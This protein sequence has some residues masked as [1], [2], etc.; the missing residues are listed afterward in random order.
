MDVTGG[1]P[2]NRSAPA[3]PCYGTLPTPN[4]SEG[5]RGQWELVKM[6]TSKTVGVRSLKAVVTTQP[7]RARQTPTGLASQLRRT[8][9]NCSPGPSS[10]EKR[11][12]TTAH[13]RGAQ[14]LTPRPC[15]TDT[16]PPRR[17]SM[18][19]RKIPVQPRRGARN[20]HFCKSG[21]GRS[22]DAHREHSIRSGTTIPDISSPPAK[23]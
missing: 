4:G 22:P 5:R 20:P 14:Y 1:R 8:L 16:P 11:K 21:E 2:C 13:P 7:M 10:S 18:G 17:D 12:S 3:R 9:C 19:E 15:T 6:S 23:R